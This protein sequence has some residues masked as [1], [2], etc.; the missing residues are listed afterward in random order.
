MIID[1][2]K[3]AKVVYL[4]LFTKITL[5]WMKDL[6]VTLKTIRLLEKTCRKKLP[7][8]GVGDEILE[9]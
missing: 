7:D 1:L 4:L 9:H 8:M 2:Y 3:V 5:K 6:N